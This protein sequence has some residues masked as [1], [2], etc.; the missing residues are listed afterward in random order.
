MF[1]KNETVTKHCEEIIERDGRKVYCGNMVRSKP[2]AINVK[3]H[4]HAESKKRKAL[5][6][7]GSVVGGMLSS[8]LDYG[9]GASIA[10]HPGGGVGAMQAHDMYTDSKRKAEREAAVARQRQAAAAFQRMSPQQ[11]EEYRRRA[12]AYYAQ[13]EQSKKRPKR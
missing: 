13:K 7:T 1:G 11:Q 3:C 9:V 4:V 10:G 6:V 5:R 12:Q 8:A 2:K